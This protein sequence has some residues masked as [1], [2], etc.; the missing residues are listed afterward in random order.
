M[1]MKEIREKLLNGAKPSKLIQEGYPKQTVYQVRGQLVKEGLLEPLPERTKGEKRV[2]ASGTEESWRQQV[3]CP[4]CGRESWWHP[5]G[6]P[7]MVI[8]CPACHEVFSPLSG[9]RYDL[10]PPRSVSRRRGGFES[11]GE[12]LKKGEET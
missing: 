2:R 4:V 12:V 3:P 11:L 8:I 7:V 6:T 5:G 1:V 9:E 10:P